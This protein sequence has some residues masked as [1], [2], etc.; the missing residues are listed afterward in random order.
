MLAPQA[1]ATVPT[2]ILAGARDRMLPPKLLAGAGCY[3]EDLAL[4]VIPGACHFL[5]DERPAEV[6]EAA[7]ALFRR[8]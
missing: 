7:R 1:Q 5:P 6:A 2:V 3:A 4:R 8:S